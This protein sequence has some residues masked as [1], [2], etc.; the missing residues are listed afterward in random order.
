MRSAAGWLTTLPPWAQCFLS[1]TLQEDGVANG[2]E[3][4]HK[5]LPIEAL[6]GEKVTA[7]LWHVPRGGQ[8]CVLCMRL[9]VRSHDIRRHSSNGPQGSAYRDLAACLSWVCCSDVKARQGSRSKVSSR[10]VPA[11]RVAA[12]GP[13]AALGGPQGARQCQ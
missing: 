3:A 13:A 12:G 10:W 7:R 2:V 5:H 4:F 1:V 11:G 6:R 8:P 9:F